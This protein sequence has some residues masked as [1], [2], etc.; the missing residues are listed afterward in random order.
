M[1]LAFLK[2]IKERFPQLKVVVGRAHTTMQP[3]DLI[4]SDNVDFVT[5]RGGGYDC[6]IGR[7]DK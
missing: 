5:L 2:V 7:G 3:Y 1:P 4:S 6:G